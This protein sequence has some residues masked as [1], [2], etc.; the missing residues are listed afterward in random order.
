MRT[1]TFKL[2]N[3]TTYTLRVELD[4][5]EFWWTEGNAGCDCNRWLMLGREYPELE[6]EDDAVQCGDT[7]E[8]IKVESPWADKDI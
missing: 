5:D 1:L 3:G 6:V 7:I 8:L 2:P 4:D